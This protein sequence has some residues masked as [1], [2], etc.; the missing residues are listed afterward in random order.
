MK[1]I[2][3]DPGIIDGV[4]PIY[5]CEISSKRRYEFSDLAR[6]YFGRLAS[7]VVSLA[8]ILYSFICIWIGL[9]P[10]GTALATV[11]PFDSRLLAQCT[12]EDFRLA[13]H[14][15]G[16]CWNSYTVSVVMVIVAVSLVLPFELGHL[17]V[18]QWVMGFIRLGVLITIIVYA[19]VG[20]LST[21]KSVP[22]T[23]FHLTGWLKGI[24]VCMYYFL[25]CQNLPSVVQPLK[26][27]S[28]MFSIIIA[29]V[30]TAAIV[31]SVVGI[32]VAI[33]FGS[34]VNEWA[35]LNWVIREGLYN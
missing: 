32:L 19:F 4:S 3:R 31:Y 10:I 12:S 5:L 8:V 13:I 22:W 18:M 21:E 11:I 34:D 17:E 33:R 6:I 27:K 14:P 25:A 30:L 15:N 35:A 2:R 28:N 9:I 29:T 26:D 23:K 7:A 20:S 24:S 1:R 16:P